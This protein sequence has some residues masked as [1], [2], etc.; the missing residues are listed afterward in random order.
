[1]SDCATPGPENYEFSVV[2]ALTAARADL[3]RECLRSVEK[4]CVG[5]RTEIIVPYDNRLGGA[6]EIAG[7]FAAARFVDCRGSIPRGTAFHS[8]L[9]L[10][11]LRARGLKEAE[12]WIVA[13]IED[14]EIVSE[15][16]ARAML[17]A[18]HSEPAVVGGAIENATNSLLAEAS[19]VCDFA[20]YFASRPAGPLGTASDANV[21]YQRAMVRDF[22]ESWSAQYDEKSFHEEIRRHGLPISFEPKALVYQNRA[23]LKIGDTLQE[24][25]AWGRWYGAMQSPE[26]SPSRR[27]IFLICAWVLPTVLTLRAVPVALSPRRLQLSIFVLPVVFVLRSAWVFGEWCGYLMP[28]RRSTL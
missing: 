23:G 6:E 2:V 4:S 18:H 24:R 28:P 8:H 21:S 27:L 10:D 5:I 20:A 11:I 26:I 17:A 7:E 9:R 13:L 15:G 16:W 22:S 14:C 1:M 12:G 25:F 3:L 19:Y